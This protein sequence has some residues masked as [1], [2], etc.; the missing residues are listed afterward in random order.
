MGK[1]ANKSKIDYKIAR[2]QRPISLY[3]EFLHFFVLTE[4][5]LHFVLLFLFQHCK[6]RDFLCNILAQNFAY[7]CHLLS[8][9]RLYLIDVVFVGCLVP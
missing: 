9:T 1:N 3:I 8:G 2:D 7:L 4:F 5:Y 6:S